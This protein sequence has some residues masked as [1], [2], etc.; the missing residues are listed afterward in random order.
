MGKSESK[1][2]SSAKKIEKTEV[3]AEVKAA[4]AVVRSA[5]SINIGISEKDRAAIAE[6]L[7]ALLADKY[8]S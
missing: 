1:D 3:K 7:S 4:P 6:S 8:F 2:K 5:S